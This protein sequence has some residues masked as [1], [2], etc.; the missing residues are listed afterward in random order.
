MTERFSASVITWASDLHIDH[1]DSV[2][3]ATLGERLRAAA[4]PLVVTG[5]VSVAPTLTAD[6]EW[7]ATG[8]AGPVFFVLGNHDHYGSSVAAVRDE[9][10]ALAE[11]NPRCQWLP[12]AGVV[13]LQGGWALVGVD[14]WADGHHGDPL[15]TPVRL[16]DDRLIGELAAYPSRRERLAVKRALADADAQRLATLLDRASAISDSILVATHVPPFVE[17]LP[18]R[19]RLATKEWLPM[20]VCEATGVV[21]RA[22]AADH[23]HHSVVVLAGHT[24]V[25]RDVRITPNLRCV[26]AGAR[27]GEPALREFTLAL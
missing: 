7:L 8:N 1:L 9:M 22:F 15:G 14:G 25:A 5:D 2:A 3:R 4:S 20:L 13:S 12:P 23:P 24:H 10:T 17:A 6:L 27:Y 11:R 19:G 16:N 26:V 18:E 21:L